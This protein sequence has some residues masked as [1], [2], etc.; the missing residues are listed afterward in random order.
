MDTGDSIVDLSLVKSKTIKHQKK[1]GIDYNALNKVAFK[2][3]Q[4]WMSK[5]IHG[6]KANCLIKCN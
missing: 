4:T 6:G 3:I 1:K 2:L 5:C